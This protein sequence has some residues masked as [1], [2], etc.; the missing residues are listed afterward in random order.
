MPLNF[1]NLSRCENPLP[2]F[3]PIA[4]VTITKSTNGYTPL[5][6]TTNTASITT[7]IS[8]YKRLEN[9]HAVLHLS[10]AVH[11]ILTILYC[12]AGGRNMHDVLHTINRGCSF[13]VW[14]ERQFWERT[15]FPAYCRFWTVQVCYGSRRLAT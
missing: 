1:W 5:N 8:C 11:D 13:P 7:T 6:E 4:F 12:M 10:R 14:S 3:V 9:A 15:V 2:V